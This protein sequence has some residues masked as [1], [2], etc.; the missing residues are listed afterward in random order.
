MA[1]DIIIKVKVDDSDLKH[2]DTLID[3]LTA[4]SK[5]MLNVFERMSKQYAAQRRQMKE[6]TASYKELAAAIKLAHDESAKPPPPPP[7]QASVPK[8]AARPGGALGGLVLGAGIGIAMTGLQAI[9]DGLMN[10]ARHVFQ[11]TAEFQKM[12]AV[13]TNTLGSSSAAKG[14]MKDIQSFAASTPF[15]V[16]EITQ[17][18]VKLANQGFT[19][20][21]QEMTKLGDL[22]ASTGKT[23]DMLAE[24]VIDAQTGEFER[25]KEF[26]I[27]A[28][29]ANG[30]VSLS[31]KGVTTTVKDSDEA[32][33]NAIMGFGQMAGVV[34]SMAAI[35][36]TLEGKVSNLGDSWD[37]LAKTIGETGRGGMIDFISALTQSVEGLTNF[38]QIQKLS[39]PISERMAATVADGT[40]ELQAEFSV[41]AQL[42]TQQH[43]SSEAKAQFGML[44][45]DLNNKYGEYLPKLLDEKS[46]LNDVANAYNIVSKA[47]EEKMII[48][49]AEAAQAEA[50]K[51]V[52]DTQ[53]KLIQLQAQQVAESNDG[54][55]GFLDTALE[56]AEKTPTI[57]AAVGLFYTSTSE[58]IEDQN[59][60][61]ELNKQQ[62]NG[63]SKAAQDMLNARG[64]NTDASQVIDARAEFAKMKEIGEVRDR[65]Q[66]EQEKGSNKLIIQAG[67]DR[68]D[69]LEKQAA[70]RNR[71]STDAAKKSADDEK[72][73]IEQIRKAKNDTSLLQIDDDKLRAAE[74]ARI[75]LAEEKEKL[76]TSTASAA[77]KNELILLLEQKLQLE[78]DK[79]YTNYRNDRAKKELDA[80]QKRVE[81]ATAE[82]MRYQDQLLADGII[83]EQE[84]ADAKEQITID[85]LERRLIYQ[86]QYQQ[87]IDTST[88][89]G[90]EAQKAA[91]EAVLSTEQKLNDER[92][93]SALRARA[94]LQKSEETR[95]NLAVEIGS[96]DERIKSIEKLRDI[97]KTK[98]ND[99]VE[100]GKLEI[101]AERQITQILT[102]EIDKQ[103]AQ[104]EK[105]IDVLGDSGK[106]VKA[107]KELAALEADRLAIITYGYNQQIAIA[108]KL[109]I[110]SAKLEQ[111]KQ[112]AITDAALKGE[113]DRL[114]FI[115]KYEDAKK[116]LRE[117]SVELMLNLIDTL[118]EAEQAKI[119]KR[120]EVNNENLAKSEEKITK[121]Q[122]QEKEATGQ[123][124]TD[125]RNLIT[126][127]QTRVNQAI[128]DN[129]RLE[130]EK[131]K[132]RKKASAARKAAAIA[133]VITQT[134]LGVISALAQVPKFDFGISA[135]ALAAIIAA[136]G[137][138]KLATI[139]AQPLAKGTVSVT[140]GVEGRDSVP[141]LLMPGEAVIPTAVARRHTA[142]IRALVN[143][144]SRIAATI[145]NNYPQHA[146]SSATNITNNYNQDGTHI[147]I[148]E[149]GF[150]VFIAKNNIRSRQLNN[151]YRV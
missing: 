15:G 75:A 23:F 43:K 91:S 51:S 44:V 37:M 96:T 107:K 117:S 5:D 147:N 62:L 36:G 29:K 42:Q 112:D 137:A 72:R 7:P 89:E 46:S 69:A 126:Q 128:N 134:A 141:A 61:L 86:Q 57:G 83:N 27:K 2:M 50:M 39:I 99:I 90:V 105:Q 104:K 143:E 4:S 98:T 25:L 97:N 59:K 118:V 26:G 139:I 109:G 113:K 108:Q 48:Q 122:E 18:F 64:I 13:L 123:R 79:I 100:Q 49:A 150:A 106:S 47:I 45:T 77:R 56:V 131:E 60:L 10:T 101:D 135:T 9:Q 127:E 14:A 81:A 52:V 22:A 80:A 94:K 119:D 133:E 55:R 21:M 8:V 116:E 115:A 88:K 1:E 138:V 124:K 87:S 121:L 103:I 68:L 16:N 149:S 130:D 41:L 92:V 145:R 19:P 28:S 78:L 3:A 114:A 148:D 53:K 66:R 54:M 67:K 63:V 65:L 74:S 38:I 17:S 40:A 102:E 120:I 31:F 30:Q 76:K 71:V 142:L 85:E 82:E 58:A 73:I 95:L 12:E 132:L 111:D 32:I 125:I 20:T 33:R 84:A 146:N 6:I 93:K 136:T 144:P 129:K 70:A 151:R 140:G 110:D 11:V 34:G 35:A 24:A